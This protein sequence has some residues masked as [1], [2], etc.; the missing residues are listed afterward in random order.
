MF[1]LIVVGDLNPDLVLTGDVTPAF[2]QREKVVAGATLTVGSS[3]GIFACGAARLGLR[4]A[5]MGLVGDD[6]FGAFMRRSLAERGVDVSGIVTS[7]V[8]TGLG[9]ILSR[10]DDRAILTYL[11]SIG[12]LRLDQLDL[13]RLAHARHLHLGSLFLLQSLRPAIPTLFQQAH[14]LGLTVSLDTNY[15]PAEAWDGGVRAALAHTDVFLP[16]ETEARALT[17][18][19]DPRAALAALAETIPTV[20]IKLGAQGAIAQRGSEV[21]VSPALP[22]SVVDTTGAGVSFDAGFVYGWLHGWP[23]ER[24]LRL[25]CAC[26]SLSAR[27]AGGVAAQ[28]TLAEALAAAELWTELTEFAE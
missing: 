26:G 17:G 9:V 16:N 7:E 3:A 14:A 5:F 12:A 13:T 8:G 24:C 21:A 22:V 28:A 19:A 15:D 10:D 11:G 27:A 4:T 20:A 6:E 23:L 18:E 1:D 2:G 25:A